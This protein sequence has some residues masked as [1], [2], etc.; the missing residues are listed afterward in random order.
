MKDKELQ[1]LIE[2]FTPKEIDDPFFGHLRF[3][4]DYRY[5]CTWRG[6]LYFKPT[7]ER[8]EIYVGGPGQD[9]PTEKEH[10]FYRGVEAKYQSLAKDAAREL[11]A[12]MRKFRPGF[13]RTDVWREFKLRA[14]QIPNCN[15]ARPW[16]WNL[17][18]SHESNPKQFSILMLDWV[19][20][21]L[22]VGGW[23]QSNNGMHPTAS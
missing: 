2:S 21:G 19:K 13:R 11:S 12:Y 4:W 15:M 14:L 1:K 3:T 8:I 23:P 20:Q 9:N 18:Y 17:T 10:E 16:H 6:S 7:E 5:P 22:W